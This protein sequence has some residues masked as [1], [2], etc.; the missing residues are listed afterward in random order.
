MFHHEPGEAGFKTTAEGLPAN[1][2]GRGDGDD[3]SLTAVLFRMLPEIVEERR[4]N[5]TDDL[6]SA[7]VHSEIEDADGSMRKISDTEFQMFIQ[8]LAIAGTET[9][10][11]LLS[12]AA[13]ILARNPDQRAILAADPSLTGNGVEELFRYE[14]PS[15]VNARWVTR[16]VDFYGQTVPAGSKIIMLNGAANRDERH[17]E[18]PDRFDVHRRI[19]RHLSL[20]YG[21]HFCIGAAL[22]RLEARI[23]VQETL[24]RFPQWQIDESELTWVHTSTVRGFAKVP[25]HLR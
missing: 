24:A 22:A 14:A 10:A 5:P 2:V 11:R 7:L 17:F 18:D 1:L 13:V 19:D 20:G 25:I 21:T 23:A 15:P 4:V 12:W 9:V 8:L 16:D 6:I 3:D